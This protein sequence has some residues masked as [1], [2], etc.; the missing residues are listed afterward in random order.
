MAIPLAHSMESDINFV[1]CLDQVVREPR[2]AA[3]AENDIAGAKSVED[4][5]VPPA[6]MPEFDDITSGWIELGDDALQP[7]AAKVKAGRKLK[8]KAARARTKE[9]GDM[10]E[11]ADECVRSAEPFDVSNQ[12]GNFDSVDKFSPSCLPPPP[13]HRGWSWP[14]IKRSVEFHGPEMVGVMGEPIA[15]RHVGSVKSIP[16]VPI[17]PTGT[18][19]IN[20]W[21]IDA[22]FFERHG[23]GFALPLDPGGMHSRGAAHILDTLFRPAS[24]ASGAALFSSREA[25]ADSADA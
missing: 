1:C 2:T 25:V 9:V 19:H 3:A 5:L 11:V 7:G 14:G 10:S 20:F 22:G 18:A 23:A 16:P 8:K 21:Q 15:C 24:F 12:F 6:V 17:E 13:G 4:A